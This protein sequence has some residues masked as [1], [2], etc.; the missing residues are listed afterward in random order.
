MVV[1]YHND[2]TDAFFDAVHRLLSEPPS[3]TLLV[4][5]E[6]R[7]VFTTTEYDVVAPCYD[8]FLHCLD[9]LKT[10]TKLHPRAS[11]LLVS[12]NSGPE[13]I[14]DTN[15]QSS[16]SENSSHEAA[17]NCLRS[18]VSS[19]A[20]KPCNGSVECCVHASTTQ[21]VEW[22]QS[23]F[24]TDHDVS[25]LNAAVNLDSGAGQNKSYSKNKGS[26]NRELCSSSHANVH[27]RK[28]KVPVFQH[29]KYSLKKLQYDDFPQYFAYDRTKELVLWKINAEIS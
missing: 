15:I 12:R 24:E 4:A 17:S 27:K 13:D 6:K 28:N 23:G 19:D 5:L 20:S 11:Q 29:I 26:S 8:Y 25:Q 7:Y 3:K 14:L 2:L 22:S 9:R 18:P 21:G 1:V 10:E 16:V